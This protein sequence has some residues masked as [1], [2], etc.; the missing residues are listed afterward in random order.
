MMAEPAPDAM[1]IARASALR[2]KLLPM[3]QGKALA[4]WA[5]MG[6]PSSVGGPQPKDCNAWLQRRSLKLGAVPGDGRCQYTAFSRAAF[7]DDQFADELQWLAVAY[8]RLHKSTFYESMQADLQDRHYALRKLVAEEKISSDDY[9]GFM[10]ALEK[11]LEWGN[12]HTLRAMTILMRLEARVIKNLNCPASA[13]EPRLHGVSKDPRDQVGNILGVIY[14][15]LDRE[16]YSTIED[17]LEQ[18]LA[19]NRST[20]LSSDVGSVYSERPGSIHTDRD[21]DITHDYEKPILALGEEYTAGELLGDGVSLGDGTRCVLPRARL[22]PY[23]V[24]AATLCSRGCTT[25]WSRLQRYVVEAATRC[26]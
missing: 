21:N 10:E 13:M 11:G 6:A 5:K 24:E 4:A 22:Q 9:D 17:D 7:N 25:R 1:M 18:P 12:D 19:T 2:D 8:L 14:L 16:H 3:P 23:V 20:S 15:F 26:I